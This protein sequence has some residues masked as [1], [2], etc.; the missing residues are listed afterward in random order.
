[1]PPIPK[2]VI[3]PDGDEKN[4]GKSL[5]DQQDLLFGGDSN[6][7]GVIKGADDSNAL[8][9]LLGGMDPGEHDIVYE[10]T[11]QVSN[12]GNIFDSQGGDAKNSD[13]FDLFGAPEESILGMCIGKVEFFP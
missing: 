13:L 3:S 2:E 5:E 9:D 12:S 1:M 10:S 4:G 7:S 8:L 6:S 11:H